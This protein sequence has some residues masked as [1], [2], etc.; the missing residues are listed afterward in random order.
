MSTARSASLT[1]S[2]HAAMCSMNLAPPTR[3]RH[4]SKRRRGNGRE[5]VVGAS[6]HT[7][8][9]PRTPGWPPSLE[10]RNWIAPWRRPPRAV[11]RAERHSS[12]SGGQATSPIAAHS[13][14]C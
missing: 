8:E 1:L 9:A 5:P 10:L 12:Q 2:R 4:P 3:L 11:V 7:I 6:E 14:S 13:N